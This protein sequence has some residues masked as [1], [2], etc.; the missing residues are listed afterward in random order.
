MPDSPLQVAKTGWPRALAAAAAILV[1]FLALTPWTTLWDRDEPRFAQ[2]T[3]EMLA[4]GN[5]LYPPFNG[6]LRTD[7]PI[8]IYWLMALSVRLL[9]A[10]E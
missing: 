3:V 2:A 8:L 1:A 4:S 5:Y 7:K 9:G 10:T 6:H